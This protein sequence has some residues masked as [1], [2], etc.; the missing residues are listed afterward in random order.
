MVPP[1]P[2]GLPAPRGHPT[3]VYVGGPPRS[4]RRSIRTKLADLVE[5]D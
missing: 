1:N 5:R 2:V 4:L 3:R